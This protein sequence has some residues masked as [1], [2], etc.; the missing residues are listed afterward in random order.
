MAVPFADEEYFTQNFGDPPSR[1]AARL[2]EELARASR[3]VRREC[4]GID[5]R[6]AK[7]VADPE[8]PAGL[9]PDVAADV[10]CEMIQSAGASPGG[11]GVTSQQM[12]AGPYQETTQFVNPVGDL[13]LTK[14]QKRLLGC[15]R[16]RAGNVDL[17][18]DVPR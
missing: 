11:I 3:Y 1:V 15:G 12:A 14:K 16:P 13:Y 5:A 6:I 8:D 4:P 9:D 2:V 10:V 7:Y 17:I 18:P